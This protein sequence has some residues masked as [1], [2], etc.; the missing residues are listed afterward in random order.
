MRNK[1]KVRI[2][3]RM[4]RRFEILYVAVHTMPRGT[5]EQFINCIVE[6]AHIGSLR[7]TMVE[8]PKTVRT[9]VCDCC[10]PAGNA[11]LPPRF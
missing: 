7:H 6:T 9:F 5:A 11:I 3:G 1:V 4:H 10:S 8:R 2:M